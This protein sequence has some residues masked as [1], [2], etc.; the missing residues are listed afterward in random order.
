MSD[1]IHPNPSFSWL[2]EIADPYMNEFHNQVNETLHLAVLKNDE[3]YYLNKWDTSR[4]LRVVIQSRTGGH[5]PLHCTGLGKMLLAGQEQSY[6]DEVIPKLKFEGFTKNQ[7]VIAAISIT[8]P[9]VR[10]TPKRKPEL[11]NE[12]KDIAGNI[13][14]EIRGNEGNLYQR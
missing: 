1:L 6:L 10:L 7:K 13:S 4:S 5:A 8:V 3:L 2:R 14:D 11:L 12:I 9:Q